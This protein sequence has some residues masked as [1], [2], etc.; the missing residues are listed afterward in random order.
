MKTRFAR[1]T[2]C[3]G[4][5]AL[6]LGAIS[7]QAQVEPADKYN[8]SR[9]S[10]FTYYGPTDG[11]YNGLLKTETVEP[12]NAPLGVT[13]LYFYDSFGNKKSATTS[14][15]GGA[16]GL[17]VF[18]ARSSYSD[19]GTGDGRFPLKSTN[20]LGQSEDKLYDDR[21]G[22]V[23]HLTGPNGLLTRWTLDDFGRKTKEL[24]ADDTSTV[25]AYCIISGLGIDDTSN[26]AIASSDPM[27]CP[28]R[29]AGETPA[30]AVSFVHSEPRD[31]HDAKMGPFVRVY[32]DKLG[33][34]I[35]SVTQTFDGAAQPTGTLIAQDTHY[36]AFGAKFVQ[37]QPYFLNNNS[38]TLDGSSDHGATRT[39]YDALGRPVTVYTADAKG[40]QAGVEFG[41]VGVR[42]AAVQTVSYAGLEVT[43]TN[44]K[45]QTRREERNIN[46][47]VVRI[48]DASGAQLVHQHDA[49]GNLVATKDALQNQVLIQYDIRGRKIAMTDPDTGLWTYDYD[50]L[51][52]LRQQV[53]ATQRAASTVTSMEYDKLGRMTK[54]SEPEYKSTWV[55]DT[56]TLGVGKLCTS[57]T[58]HGVNRT[59]VYDSLGRP[60]STRTALTT[61]GPIVA[62]AV[63]YDDRTG[64][65][66][67][68]TYPTGLQVS[69]GYTP[70]G[71]LE[72]LSLA[73]VATLNPL[74]STPG[75]T[76]GAGTTL[77]A[78]TVLWQA[79][80]FNAWGK[81][82]QQTFGVD[83]LSKAAFEAATGRVSK[84]TAGVGGATNV[85]NQDYTWDSLNN[86][87]SRTDHIGDGAGAV[88]EVFTYG[89][90]LNRLTHYRVSAPAIPDAT[91]DV[92][93]HYNA[94]GM[95]LYKSDV[96]NYRYNVQGGALPHAL[97]GVA[98]ALTSTYDYDHNGNLKAA[99]S[100]SY[101]KIAYT[102]FNLPDETIGIEGR[103]GAPRYTWG[104]DENHQR[105]KEVRTSAGSTRTTWMLHPDNAGGLGFEREE[106]SA[107]ASNRHYLSAGGQAIGVLVSTGA[108][109][110][111][112][113]ALTPPVAASITLVKLEYWHRDHLGSLV[114]TTDHT[115]AVTA[116]YAY[117]PF[118]KRRFTNGTYD[119]FGT[120]V[121]DWT[122]NTNAGT[123][124]GYTGHEHLDDVG[125]V[126]MNGRIFDPTLGVFLQGD[127]FIQDPGNLQ[128]FNRYGYCYNNPLT[129]TDPSGQMNFVTRLWKKLWNNKVVRTVIIAVASYYT[130]GAALDWYAGSVAAT[131]GYAAAGSAAAAAGADTALVAMAS[132][133]AYS[134][135]YLAAASSM[136]GGMVAGAAGGFAAGFVSSSGDVRAGLNG[137]AT[138]AIFGGVAGNYG[139]D[140][141]AERVGVTAGATGLISVAN[142]GRFSDGF[143]DGFLSS[144]LSLTVSLAGQ[145]TDSLKRLSCEVSPKESI[146]GFNRWGELLTD[147]GRNVQCQNGPGTCW[148]S[149][150][151]TESGM[152]Q[153]GAG[154]FDK[155]WNPAG[156]YYSEN[157]YLGRFINNVSKVHDLFNSWGYDGSTGAWISRGPV[158]DSLFQL[159]SFAGMIPAAAISGLANANNPL[160]MRTGR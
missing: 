41:P 35:R 126:H 37:T 91:R 122:S 45:G 20:A 58:E 131:S 108:L 93:L 70:R 159:Y 145:T 34:T 107:G 26:S 157:S 149:N 72:K 160:L 109:P 64:R 87:G 25:Y 116:R 100:G 80:T 71:F 14:N 56:C 7:A 148:G 73:T 112:G 46:G 24:R 5:A 103:D 77:S 29:E 11:K 9:T 38:S 79:Q 96:G 86:L 83:V 55:Y 61:G 17:A 138:G 117:D 88:G 12:D 60:E 129:C 15:L 28:P 154:L 110:E 21:T 8:Y 31:T 74:P 104:Y 16:S 155:D 66:S 141:S 81:A 65:V 52:Q 6:L 44:D 113:G 78:G 152:G 124:R 156:H 97:Q 54:R 132:S 123:D 134:S 63:A 99:S 106:S 30:G 27:D 10:S 82:E 94:L 69:Y 101:Q 39:D 40:S 143:R 4:L 151:L 19:F 136:T 102:S 95:L 85:V 18:D 32:S 128:N 13:T 47:K 75:G 127:P 23:T 150:W 137:A 22:G 84:L 118:G 119:A 115:G 68:Q 130:A 147:G 76:A 57:S 133:S 140:W 62:S 50:A 142:G 146:C 59:M 3:L 67:R 158:Y 98:G 42:T 105:I 51:G 111:L 53:S 2:L 139:S 36:N 33:R 49:F 144:V 120:L 89:D 135:A 48:T 90:Q 114:A 92:D 153:E 43:T 121:V 125:L 1:S